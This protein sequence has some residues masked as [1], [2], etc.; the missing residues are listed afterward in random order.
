[1]ALHCKIQ[2]KDPG[3]LVGFLFE[4]ITEPGIYKRSDVDWSANL[5]VILPVKENPRFYFAPDGNVGIWRNCSSARR[6]LPSSQ[7]IVLSGGE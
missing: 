6:F 4:E 5:Y 2:D 1:M 3:N 7:A